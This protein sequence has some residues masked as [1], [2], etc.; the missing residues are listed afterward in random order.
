[1]YFY[2]EYNHAIYNTIIDVFH[3]QTKLFLKKVGKNLNGHP[4]YAI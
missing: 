1:M 2:M 3:T 4:V